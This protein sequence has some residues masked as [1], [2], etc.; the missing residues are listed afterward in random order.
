VKQLSIS[1]DEDAIQS[2]L[3]KLYEKKKQSGFSSNELTIEESEALLVG[4]VQAYSRTTLILD[5]L[6]ECD[7]KY[8]VKI[9]ELFNRLINYSKQLKIFISSRRDQ[10]IVHQLKKRADVGVEAT[11][12]R[13]DISKF[14]ADAIDRGQ[15]QRNT[16]I[17]EDLREEI[18][19]TIL[20]KSGGMWV[21][22]Y[23]SPLACMSY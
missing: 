23:L 16:K 8:R 3:V 1:S 9:I 2:V 6:D 20:N 13:D 18:V 4:L 12:N 14:V 10:D 17:P 11:N 7:Q 15:E 5:A 19:Q 22:L 21:T